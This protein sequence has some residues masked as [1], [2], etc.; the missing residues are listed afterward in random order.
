MNIQFEHPL[1]IA[2]NTD[3]YALFGY[4]P[5]HIRAHTL[6]IVAGAKNREHPGWT[7][8]NIAERIKAR[9]TIVTSERRC[10]LPCVR[11]SVLDGSLV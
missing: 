7:L 2:A 6:L 1:V 10:W 8:H 9:D 3:D 11:V 5:C 4:P